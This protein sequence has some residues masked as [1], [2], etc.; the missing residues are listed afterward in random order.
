MGLVLMAGVALG[1]A[2]AFLLVAHDR[3]QRAVEA[4]GKA[5]EASVPKEEMPVVQAL[6]LENP[7]QVSAGS[8]GIPAAQQEAA[9]P[10]QDETAS[11][12]SLWVS[13]DTPPAPASVP[14]GTSRA[15][16]GEGTSRALPFLGVRCENGYVVETWPGGPFSLTWPEEVSPPDVGPL[17]ITPDHPMLLGAVVLGNVPKEAAC[18]A[19]KRDVL[20]FKPGALIKV[21][22]SPD[23]HSIL[24]YRVVLQKRPPEAD[25]SWF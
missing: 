2:A 22:L 10:V 8:P 20:S 16:S 6:P 7:P 15:A 19:L 23:G 9:N 18:Y 13:K 24:S 5:Y 1:A 21:R 4:L 12:A 17:T 11:N 3:S 25:P 14:E